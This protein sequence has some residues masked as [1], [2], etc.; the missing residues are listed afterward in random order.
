MTEK[1]VLV[2]DNDKLYVELLSDIL[3]ERGYSVI[4]AYDGMEALKKT[5]EESLQLII[6]DLI[7]PKVDGIRFCKYLKKDPAFNHI[8]IVILS[9]TVIEDITELKE[10]GGDAY[11]PKS[12]IEEVKRNI[13]QI[14]TKLEEKGSIEEVSLVDGIKFQPRPIVG[15]LLLDKKHMEMV[16]QRMGEGVIEVDA[17]GRITWINPAALEIFGKSEIQLIGTRIIDSLDIAKDPEL[18]EIIDDLSTSSGFIQRSV[19]IPYGERTLRLNITNLIEAET[20]YLGFILLVQDVTPLIDQINKFGEAHDKLF[21]A[22]RMAT[23]GQLIVNI[24]NEIKDPLTSVLGYTGFLLNKMDDGNPQKKELTLIH[25]AAIRAR[26]IIKELLNLVY[27]GEPKLETA[28]LVK[29]L[30][31]T[32]LLVRNRAESLKIKILENYEPGL[33]LVDVNVNFLKQAFLNIINNAVDAMPEGGT[34][35]ITAKQGEEH[36]VIQ[37]EDTGCGMTPQVL[38]K[39]FTPFFTTKERTKGIGLGLSISMGIIRNHGGNVEVKSQVGRG[40]IFIVRLPVKGRG[41]G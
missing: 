14:L 23:L 25:D 8:P 26:T 11:I 32:L 5:R 20:T 31:N 18:K 17:T 21:K 9:G 2:V 38:N 3:L 29:E 7:M 36:L 16:I 27:Q 41:N 19:T 39:L 1:N 40:T 15:E 4:R 28:S 37:F 35:S 34:L 10:I 12:S 6:T 22:V 13:L 24:S 30:K 33:S